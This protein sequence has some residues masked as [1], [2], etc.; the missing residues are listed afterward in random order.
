MIR[1][2]LLFVSSLLACGTARS[3]DPLDCMPKSARVVVVVDNPRK[4]AETITGLDAFKRAQ[5]LAQV[6]ELYDSTT[7]RRLLKLLAFAEKELG[8]KWPDLLDQIAGNGLALGLRFGADPAPAIAVACGTDPQQVAKAFDLAVQS[9]DEELARQGAKERLKVEQNE[10]VSLA[11]FGTDIHFARVESTILVSNGLDFLKEAIALAQAKPKGN[12]SIHKAR[13][14]AAKLLPKTPL[15]WVWLNFA[16]V[17]ESKE[18]KDFFDATRQDFI[19]TLGAGSTIDCLRR[20]DCVAVG[21]Y[22]EASGFRV[23]VRLPAGREG[24]WSDLAL[25]VPPKGSQ[26]SLPLLEPPGTIYSQS[27][28][29][30]VGYMWKHRDRMITGDSLKQFEK[31]EKEVSKIIPADV[32]LGELLEMWGPQH[33]IVVVNHDKRPYKTEPELKLPAFGYVATMRDKKF[34][35]NL[36][37]IAR[38]VALIGTLQ[39]GLKSTEVEHEGVIITGYRFPENKTVP[40]DPQGVR[41]NF[42]PCFAVVGDEMIFASTI[43]LG[44]KLITELKKPRRSGNTAV[45]MAKASATDGANV[46]AGLSDPLITD[47]VLGRG[48][49]LTEARTEIANLVAWV[50]T[51]GTAQIEIDITAT[52]YRLDVVWTPEKK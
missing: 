42:E 47:A 18:A 40:D 30:D 25:H 50:R 36:E 3:A 32:K 4:L 9:L 14:D 39:F 2:T 23:R 19:Q 44:K 22:R 13:Q 49:G 6:R 48:L 45:W 26:G 52:E 17:K 10:G 12:P 31:G 7:A 46:L 24:L 38:A 11:H 51:L 35:E 5:T 1:L 28:H 27:F 20:S 8:A 21:L 16:S 15:A 33:R 29:L 34:G 43:E 37:S 41:F